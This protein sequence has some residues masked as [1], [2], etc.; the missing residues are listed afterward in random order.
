MFLRRTA[1][2]LTAVLGAVAL[3][4]CSVIAADDPTPTPASTPSP[5]ATITLADDFPFDA[6]SGLDSSS[7]IQWADT[8]GGADGFTVASAD[9]GNGRWS[10]QQTSSQ[11][12]IGFWQTK[13]DDLDLTQDE[14]TLSDT[15]LAQE[16]GTSD[17]AS[18]TK[19]AYDDALPTQS[20][21]NGT[22]RV[23][24]VVSTNSKN[25]ASSIV[26]ARV[27]RSVKVG[28][29]TSVDCP[30]GF[31]AAQVRDQLAPTGIRMIIRPAS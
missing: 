27:F 31:S 29:L 14:R 1:L 3:S 7:T 13:V 19:Y 15:M 4:G 5:S 25:G 2:L 23:R 26:S 16:Y 8:M 10:Y 12:I 20:S 9:D 22:V 21:G 18:V 11:C 6:A 17:V 28:L 30:D 24:S